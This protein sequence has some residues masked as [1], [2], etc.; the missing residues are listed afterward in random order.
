MR[1]GQFEYIHEFRERIKE[2]L[3]LQRKHHEIIDN[4]PNPTIQ[5]A[6]KR[7][8]KEYLYY[9]T[10]WEAKD[11]LGNLIKC[12]HENE[13]KYTQQTNHIKTKYNSNTREEE[14]YYEKGSPRDVYTIP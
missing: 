7:E 10:E 12:S 14:A 2:I 1:E 5:Q 8:R 9:T 3:W 11:R 4:N 6:P 13:A